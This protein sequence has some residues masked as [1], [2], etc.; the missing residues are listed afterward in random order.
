[1]GEDEQYPLPDDW[2][3]WNDTPFKTDSTAKRILYA[4]NEEGCSVEIWVDAAG[5]YVLADDAPV[6]V[7]EVV[8]TRFR[9]CEDRAAEQIWEDVGDAADKERG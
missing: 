5:P 9:Q 4:G 2:S 8:L 7:V 6:A 3:W 1:M